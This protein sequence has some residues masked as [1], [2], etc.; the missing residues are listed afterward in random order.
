MEINFMKKKD[1]YKSKIENILKKKSHSLIEIDN[2]VKKH[3]N[4]SNKRFTKKGFYEA[5]ME[6]LNDNKIAISSYDFGVH[7]I[8]DNRIQSFKREGIIFE[9]VKRSEAEIISL[10]NQMEDYKLKKSKNAEK[11]LRKIFEYKYREYEK[12]EHKFYKSL[13][14]K[15][16]SLPAQK[17]KEEDIEYVN[18]M[19]QKQFESNKV[20]YNNHLSK[21]AKEG[22]EW[23]FVYKDIEERPPRVH[24]DFIEFNK[25]LK[26]ILLRF[27]ANLHEGSKIWYIPDLT[28][29]EAWKITMQRYSMNSIYGAKTIYEM[30]DDT[31]NDLWREI[32]YSKAEWI[33]KE[34]N[35]N[36]EKYLK[37]WY[38]FDTKKTDDDVYEFFNIVLF[39]VNTH[40]NYKSL[41]HHFALALSD[42]RASNDW[43]ELFI[44]Y[45][46]SEPFRLKFQKDL[47]IKE[48][49]NVL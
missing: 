21:N 9:W 37:Q 31:L 19:A 23:R 13:L 48:P 39:F 44:N 15:V 27:P 12:E 6:L 42:A 7:D 28:P 29:E 24:P 47:G 43:F 36:P 16:R 5:L 26:R 10:L 49:K 35:G 32:G 17:T 41:K 45:V 2:K 33:D 18:E 22:K 14:S 38:F 25:A 20:K 34:G 8:K 11:K 4:D 46:I 40:E 1:L 30:N 3:L